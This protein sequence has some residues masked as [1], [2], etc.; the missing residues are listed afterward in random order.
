MRTNN[1]FRAWVKSSVETGVE[2]G[3]LS[4]SFVRMDKMFIK[5]AKQRQSVKRQIKRAVA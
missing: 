1:Q 2:T 5:A 3:C 4:K